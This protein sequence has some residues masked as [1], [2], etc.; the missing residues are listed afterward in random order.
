VIWLLVA[1]VAVI[2]TGVVLLAWLACLIPVCRRCVVRRP[3]FLPDET[4]R[5][6]P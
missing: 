6:K 4:F 2:L 3:G 1:L 5:G